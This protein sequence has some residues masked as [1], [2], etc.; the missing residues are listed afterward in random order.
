VRSERERELVFLF[1]RLPRERERIPIFLF[2]S[3]RTAL[4]QLSPPRPRG[5]PTGE[6]VCVDKYSDLR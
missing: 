5:V 6:L 3:G 1:S 2:I 4:A